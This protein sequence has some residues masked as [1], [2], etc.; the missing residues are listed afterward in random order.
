MIYFFFD[1]LTFKILHVCY[2]DEEFFNFMD[3]SSYSFLSSNFGS[4]LVCY[5]LPERKLFSL[6]KN[7]SLDFLRSDLDD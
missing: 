1:K 4:D 5:P 2:S 6:L 7:N 3:S